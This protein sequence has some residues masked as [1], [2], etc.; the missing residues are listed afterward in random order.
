MQTDI[1]HL[2]AIFLGL[3]VKA[4]IR[5]VNEPFSNLI[6]HKMMGWQWHQLDYMQIISTSLLDR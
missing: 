1:Y 5:M 3:P 6:K 4:S 2:M